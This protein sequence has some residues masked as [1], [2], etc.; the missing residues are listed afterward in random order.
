MKEPHDVFANNLKEY[1]AWFNQHPWVYATELELLKRLLP[2]KGVGL[3]IGV[4]TGRFAGPLRIPVGVDL[5]EPCLELAKRRGVE[6]LWADAH[7]L[8]F[9]DESFD[10]ALMMVTICFVEDPV[11]ALKEARRVLKRKGILVLGIVDR[12]SPLGKT[13]QAKKKKSPFYKHARFFSTEEV[14]QMLE[15]V[16][17]RTKRILQTLFTD[18]LDSIARLDQIREGYGEGGFVGLKA[19]KA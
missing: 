6:A 8:P 1:E 16:G 5:C 7:N 17:F 3:E 15:E 12:D 4:G 14:K 19:V 9:E 2:E 18:D 11:Q 13:Y 10:Y